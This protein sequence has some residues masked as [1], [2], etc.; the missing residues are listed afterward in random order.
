MISEARLMQLKANAEENG[1]PQ[2]IPHWQDQL[3]EV[4][5]DARMSAR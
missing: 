4:Q 5:H 2:D 1:Y 3:D